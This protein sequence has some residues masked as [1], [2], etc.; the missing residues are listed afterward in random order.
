MIDLIERNSVSITFVQS[1]DNGRW[2]V[3]QRR[4][5]AAEDATATWCNFTVSVRQDD[6]YDDNA[7]DAVQNDQQQQ[8]QQQNQQLDADMIEYGDFSHFDAD[9]YYAD[10]D[11]NDTDDMDDEPRAA[12]FTRLKKM[13]AVQAVV[14]PAGATILYK[15]PADGQS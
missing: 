4:R 5:S 10:E 14:K 3:R 9:D 13:E 12:A 11:T 7:D 15:C 8:Q 6:D 1:S 2:S